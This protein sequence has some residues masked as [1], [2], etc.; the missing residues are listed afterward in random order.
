MSSSAPSS[1][2]SIDTSVLMDW[3]ARVYPTDVFISLVARM[4]EIVLAK[5]CFAAELVRE[6]LGAVGGAAL[7]G[8]ADAR[9]GL[10]VP[11]AELLATALDI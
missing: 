8:W 11:T 4:D 2:Y 1:V 9:P 6:E 3:Q 5:R 7:A 10:F